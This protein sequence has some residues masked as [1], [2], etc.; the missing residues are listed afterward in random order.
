[1]KR[2]IITRA[3]PKSPVSEVFRTLRTN[4]QYM[5]KSN[6]CQ[7][8]VITSTVQGEGKSFVAANLAVTFAQAS[9]KTL[10]IDADMRRPRQH[11]VFGVDMF[12]GLSNY[13]SGI[14]LSRSRHEISIKECIYATKI[15]N[16][17]LMPSGNIPPNPSELLQSRKLNALLDEI[18]P[19][20]DVIIFDGAPCLL[21]TD[22]TIIS[23]V[24]DATI[25]VASQNKTKMDDLKEAKRRINHVGGH[26]AGVV[27]NRVKVSKAKYSEKYYYESNEA[28]PTIT[29]RTKRA[30][31]EGGYDEQDDESQ[32]SN[33]SKDKY[34]SRRSF[35]SKF[36]RPER[37]SRNDETSQSNNSER[38][39]RVDRSSRGSSTLSDR[40]LKTSENF[41]KTKE[42]KIPSSEVTDDKIRDIIEQINKLKEGN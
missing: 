11:T 15:D 17:Y 34:L 20:F 10:I 28:L 41:T 9:K 40:D 21:V 42:I 26:I 37:T 24:V 30:D 22:S 19:N 29:S 7:T 5:K 6:S 33:A 35:S 4:L 8:L 36:D 14:N 38:A 2:E 16:L 27:L 1:M 12:P 13:L 18:E 3:D 39:N 31:R 23:R 25:L 32:A